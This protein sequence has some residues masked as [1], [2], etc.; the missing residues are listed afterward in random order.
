MI[1]KVSNTEFEESIKE[2]PIPYG[3]SG[4]WETSKGTY[5]GFSYD[6]GVRF[7]A[8]TLQE[9]KTIQDYNSNIWNKP[10]AYE[11]ILDKV[12]QHNISC[13]LKKL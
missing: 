2:C 8:T 7:R 13:K 9:A 5:F 3:P 11:L 1:S 12:K 6:N 10:N 4:I